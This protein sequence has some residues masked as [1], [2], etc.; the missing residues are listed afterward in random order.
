MQHHTHPKPLIDQGAK[1]A[2]A[3]GV[4]RSHLWPEV[5]KAH[6]AKF[7]DCACC[8]SG[9]NLQAP[10][11][12]HHIIPFHFCILLGRPDLE[13]DQRNLLTLCEADRLHTAP[14]H[15]LLVG[16]FRDWQSF[17]YSVATDAAEKWHG[18]SEPQIQILAEWQSLRAS[19]PSHW[20]HMTDEQKQTLKMYLATNFPHGLTTPT[21][22]R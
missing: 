20:E 8:A 19:R 22:A 14:D 18:M 2:K 4:H 9:T 13:L 11:Q 12:V 17:N 3:H 7:P 15:H 10:V 6:R 21:T 5:E 1:A 16:H